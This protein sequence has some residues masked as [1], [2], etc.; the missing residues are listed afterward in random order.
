[1]D[2]LIAVVIGVGA[3]VVLAAVVWFALLG[4]NVIDPVTG[5]IGTRWSRR[6]NAYRRKRSLKR[7]PP[8]VPAPPTAP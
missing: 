7:L 5:A 4:V 6:I 8:D 1:M 2:L 3:V